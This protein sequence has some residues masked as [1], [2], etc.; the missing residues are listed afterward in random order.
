MVEDDVAL[1]LRQFLGIRLVRNRLLEVDD[2][3][4]AVDGRHRA[5]QI[6]VDAREALD[7]VGQVDGVRQEGDKCAGRQLL[8]DDL[9]AAEPDDDRDRDGREELD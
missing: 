5:L 7:R 3:E 2:G 1:D 9:V 4:D 8:V 6:A